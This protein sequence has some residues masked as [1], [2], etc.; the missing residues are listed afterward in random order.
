ML[1]AKGY[2]DADND[3]HQV[4]WINSVFVFTKRNQHSPVLFLYQKLPV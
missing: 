2:K 1:G 4:L 3:P